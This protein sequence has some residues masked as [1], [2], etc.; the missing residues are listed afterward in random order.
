MIDQVN[1]LFVPV[2]GKWLKSNEFCINRV[3]Q[4]N[5]L[6]SS[7]YF[8][9]HYCVPNNCITYRYNRKCCSAK[10]TLIMKYYFHDLF[11]FSMGE[12]FDP[13]KIESITVA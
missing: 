2:G 7:D 1:E 4:E 5:Y 6:T 3:E 11:P 12:L 9:G 13:D 10:M 8:L